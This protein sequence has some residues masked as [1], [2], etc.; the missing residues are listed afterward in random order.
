VSMWEKGEKEQRGNYQ[1][2]KKIM[3]FKLSGLNRQLRD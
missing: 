3:K 2:N 1:E